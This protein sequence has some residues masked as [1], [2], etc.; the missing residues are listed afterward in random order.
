MGNNKVANRAIA[1]ASIILSICTFLLSHLGGPKP[2]N[3]HLL[4]DAIALAPADVHQI[5]ACALAA[6]EDAIAME[7]AVA[8]SL[9][10]GQGFSTL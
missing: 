10:A 9:L 5:L 1:A 3:P 6:L 4:P 8:S 7:E 2:R